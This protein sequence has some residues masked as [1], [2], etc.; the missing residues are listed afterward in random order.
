MS[1]MRLNLSRDLCVWHWSD[2]V[3]AA[4]LRLNWQAASILLVLIDSVHKVY[5]RLSTHLLPYHTAF[6][7]K[8]TVKGSLK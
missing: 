6:N 3:R 5:C 1:C 4:G 7:R 8:Q 2:F